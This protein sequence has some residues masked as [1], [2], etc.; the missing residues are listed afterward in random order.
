MEGSGSSR[1]VVLMAFGLPVM[2]TVIVMGSMYAGHIMTTRSDR[3]TNVMVTAAPPTV[4]VDV[5]VPENVPPNIQ[6]SAPPATVDVHVPQQP[7]PM[8]TVNTPQAEPPS[9][10]VNPPA[11]IVTFIEHREESRAAEK[12]EKAAPEKAA[13][14]KSAEAKPAEAKP[15][16]AKPAATETK[17]EITAATAAKPAQEMPPTPVPNALKPAAETAKPRSDNEGSKLNSSNT[18]ALSSSEEV[19]PLLVSA[20]HAPEAAAKPLSINTLYECANQYIETY[21]LKNG[22]NPAAEARKWNR[23]WQANVEQAINDNIDSGEQS[24]I[25]RIVIAKRDCFNIEKASPE[26]IVE[27]CRIILRYRDGQ[28]AWLEAMKEALTQDNLKK[29]VAF[30]NAGPQ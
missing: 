22:L 4:D 8:V 9:I 1:Q 19:R 16:E 10:T 13:E 17:P 29:T 11:P 2:T 20:V 24:Y 3:P 27:A 21:C 23:M 14:V 18:S 5:Q 6:V 28:L 26:K 15:A 12:I 30:L 7:A 25:N